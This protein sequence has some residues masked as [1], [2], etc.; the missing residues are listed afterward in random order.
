MAGTLTEAAHARLGIA[1]SSIVWLGEA[2]TSDATRYGGQ[3]T[4]ENIE[5]TLSQIAAR[6]GAGAQVAVVLIGHGSGEG[7]ESKVSLPGPDMTAADFARL[8]SRLTT[9]RVA[10]IDLTSASGDVLP[11]L[12]APNRVVITATKSAF[13]RN[14]SRFGDYFVRALAQDGAD[15]DK[16]GRVSLLEAFRFASA[17]TKRFYE[18]ESRLATEHPQLDDDGDHRGGAGTDGESDGRLARRFFLDG[19]AGVTRVAGGDVRVTALYQR[20]DSLNDRIERLKAS[21]ATMSADAFEGQ[22]TE[23]LTTLAATTREIR[24][25]EGRP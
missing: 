6:A 24:R 19:G 5:R 7:A 8:L 21:K 25:L 15:V 16:D 10:F 14:E 18:T 1:D 12:S 23:L 20:K 9:Q 2:K 17:E 11:V 4:R 22:L 13:E 3:A